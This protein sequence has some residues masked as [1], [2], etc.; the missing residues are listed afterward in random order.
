M[1]TGRIVDIQ[2]ESLAHDTALKLQ[3][4]QPVVTSGDDAGRHRGPVVHR[5]GLPERR[6]GLS[7]L[8][9]AER[10]GTHRLGH[11]VEEV[12]NR[13]KVGAGQAD[14]LKVRD[15]RFLLSGGFPPLAWRLTGR[16][17]HRV[18]QHDLRGNSSG[19]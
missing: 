8:G 10:L 19:L 4:K 13:I 2:A 5:P 18:E 7:G 17:Y 3:R 15:P 1:T 14:S 6:V 16:R 11:V 9:L 12:L